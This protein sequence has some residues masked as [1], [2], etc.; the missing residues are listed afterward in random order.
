MS[1]DKLIETLDHALKFDDRISQLA[2]PLRF[3]L[4]SP[5]SFKKVSI[6]DP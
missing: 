5:I 1:V 6:F 4:M 3:S 2:M